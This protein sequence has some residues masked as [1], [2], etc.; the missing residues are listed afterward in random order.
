MTIAATSSVNFLEI[1]GG[2]MKKVMG[3]MFAIASASVVAMAGF[4]L[5]DDVTAATGVPEINP[6]SA[7]GALTLLGGAILVLRA[8]LKK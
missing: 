1:I 8:R 3:L 5:I 2:Y 4:E 6:A 7:V